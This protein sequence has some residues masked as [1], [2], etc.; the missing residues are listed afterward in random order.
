[1]ST[2][3]QRKCQNRLGLR[4]FKFAKNISREH[5]MDVTPCVRWP[6]SVA[7]QY[8]VYGGSVYLQ[9]MGGDS[10][11]LIL[12]SRSILFMKIYLRHTC[13]YSFTV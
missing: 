4:F 13:I 3:G 12:V 10:A 8:I 5:G 9:F 2:L 11:S 6:I 7:G 1:M